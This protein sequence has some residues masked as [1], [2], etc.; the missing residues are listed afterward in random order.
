VVVTAN[1]MVHA[2]PSL[3]ST[4]SVLAEGVDFGA[5]DI[6][7]FGTETI[8]VHNLGWT[9]QQARLYLR[10]AVITGG[11]GRFVIVRGFSPTYVS[12]VGARYE[13]AF[14]SSGATTDSTYTA[15]LTISASD[16]TIPGWQPQ[17]DLQI[18]LMATVTNGPADAGDPRAPRATRLYA[19]APNPLLSRSALRF[20]LALRTEVRIDV[21]DVNGRHV[22]TPAHRDFEP[23]S[24]TIGWDGRGESGVDLGAGLYF[25]RM[26]GPGIPTQ[27]TRIAIVR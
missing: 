16:D 15:T 21:F 5:H 7:S 14:L 19:P 27:S 17:P 13:L 10:D 18:S 1:V 12:G 23:G 3:D 20:D 8:D 4:T 24:W 2:S 26:S 22:A 11:D 25:I 9:A 6:G